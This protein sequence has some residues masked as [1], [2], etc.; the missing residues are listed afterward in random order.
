[1]FGFDAS[2]ISGVVG[3]VS[4]E[5]ELNSWQ[6]GFVVSAPTLGAVIA[7][8]SGGPLADH[9]GR[10]RILILIAALYVVSA[11]FSALAPNYETLVMARFI[12]GL[13]FASL[14]LAPIYIA[15]ISLPESRGRLV[16]INQLNIVV[17]L[18][19]AYFINYMILSA[20]QSGSAWVTSLGL[21]T[22][23]WRWML[24]I[25]LLPAS[26]FLITLF[27]I[28]ESPRWKI[29]KGHKAD[30]MAILQ[31]LRSNQ[32]IQHEIKEIE[33]SVAES[34]Q[35]VLARLRVLLSNKW[36][37]ALVVGIVIGIFQQITGINAIF[38]YAPTIFEQSGVGTN[39][40]FAQ[41]IWVGVINVIFT[42]IAM[43]LIDRMGRK[44]LL[45]IG[46]GGIFVCMAICAQGFKSAT[47]TLQE[48]DIHALEST[49]VQERLAPMTNRTYDSDI[50]FRSELK[51]LLGEETAS[52]YDAML[53]NRAIDINSTQVLFGILGFVAFFALSLGPVMWCLLAEIFPNS[54]RG[55]AMAFVGMINSGSSFL[56][57]L[58][59]PWEISTLGAA[60]TFAIYSIFALIGLALI[61][62]LLPE[63]K[64]KSLEEL[65]QA[66]AR[67]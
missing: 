42:L 11:A 59:F 60:M 64:Q 14:N 13:A 30:G 1:M 63:T 27:F 67:D 31:K 55:V 22:H 10:K 18:S 32:E 34:N 62:W 20:S 47:F 43:G 37:L 15:E 24:G 17:G 4:A 54:L 38:F 8:M 3:F 26:I 36:R 7:A 9:F 16:S 5:F 44:P 28:P 66:F 39:A 51:R 6:T 57:Q 29:L 61:A 23:T 2:V 25:E 65:E 53:T 46:L 49:D 48:S 33:D 40:A 50:E 19:A 35:S 45:M 41:A 58:V 56:V 12:G 21:D 52:Q